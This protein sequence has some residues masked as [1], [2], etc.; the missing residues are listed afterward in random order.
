MMF[1]SGTK[2]HTI[3]YA[4]VEKSSIDLST[5][6]LTVEQLKIL[7]YFARDLR[8][9]RSST[10]FKEGSGTLTGTA[11]N[12]ATKMSLAT[13]AS[14]E[15]IRSFVTIFRRL[16]MAKETANFCVSTNV[17]VSAVRPHP[18]AEWV[19]AEVSDFKDGLLKPSQ[20]A[21]FLG[22]ARPTFSVKCL[23]DV[24]LYTR[25]AHQPDA[26]RSR[27]FQQ[28]LREVGGDDA[29]FTYLFLHE[30]WQLA[31]VMSNVGQQISR[32]LDLY[33]QTHRT[34]CDLVDS[35]AA[36]HPGI[37]QLEKAKDREHRVLVEKARGIAEAMWRTVGQPPGGPG[38]FLQRAMTQLRQQ[39]E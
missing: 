20:F 23:I 29:V 25:Y 4:M 14:D 18:I 31:I 26:K 19:D 1:S 39:L 13:A 10:F 36:N 30:I 28:C 15:E 24:F 33:C 17:Y 8:E 35:P 34:S 37:G 5:I 11:G 38:Q 7:G 22:T 27:Q 16:Y 3:K 12:H 32:F 9:L 6:S 2:P 21:P